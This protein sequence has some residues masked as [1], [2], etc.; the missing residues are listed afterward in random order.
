VKSPPPVFAGRTPFRARQEVLERHVQEGAAR[1]R[2]DLA[3]E[4]EI[5]VDMDAP[6][7]AFGHPRGD[8][9]FAVDEHGLPVADED[10]GGNG[11]EAVPG[12]KEPAR[13]VERGA[14]EP[15]VD[16]P[17][18]GLMPLAEGEG[19]LVALDPLIGRQRKVDSIRVVAAAPTRRV[20]VRRDAVQRRPPRSKWAL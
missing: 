20:V 8:A 10:P 14:D 7:A 15:A 6:P 5:A 12:G 18:P 4:V 1:L 9:E 11:R 2:E 19:G 13:L 17:R 3:L 16:D